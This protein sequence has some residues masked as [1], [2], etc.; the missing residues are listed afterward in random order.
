MKFKLDENLPTEAAAEL[1]RLG[2]DIDTVQ[3]ENLVGHADDEVWSTAQTDQRCLITQ[4]LDFS[5][6]RRFAPGEH[7]GI[8]LIRLR[9]PSRRRLFNRIL[10]LFRNEDTES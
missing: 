3:Q 8:I 2:H 6:A 5:D 4:D 7:Y 9:S 1:T 10:E